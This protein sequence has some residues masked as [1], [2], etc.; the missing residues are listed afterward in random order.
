MT[1]LKT[2]VV[3]PTPLERVLGLRPELLALYREFYGTLW[4][5]RLVS[6]ALLEMCRL[7]IASLHGCAAEGA[8]RHVASGVTEQQVAALEVWRSASCFSPVERA[9]LTIAEKIPW[10]PREISDDEVAVLRAHLSDAETVA[11]MLALNLF[12]VQCRLRLALG[13]E[14]RPASVDAPAS[15]RGVLY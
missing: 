12:D 13:V 3:A 11:L 7:R 2:D 14:A 10:A 8:I 6:S 5:D 1:W 4:D 9:A 15:A